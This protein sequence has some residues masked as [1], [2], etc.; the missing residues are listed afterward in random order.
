MVDRAGATGNAVLDHLEPSLVQKLDPDLRPRDLVLRD[1]LTERGEKVEDVF[2]VT[3]GLVSMLTTMADGSSVESGVVGSEGVAGVPAAVGTGRATHG[4]AIVQ[5][6]GRALAMAADRFREMVAEES[7]LRDLVDRYT[8]AVL[9]VATQNVACNRLHPVEGRASR[10]LLMTRDRTE[11]DVFPMT[12]EFLS[13]MLGV[14]RASVSEAAE[15]LQE[16]GAIEYRRGEIRILDRSRLE[17]SACE[18]YAVVSGVFDGL[19][20]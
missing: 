1:V 16:R 11:S 20:D 6:P 14:R 4:T 12:H 3:K 17:A 5:V 13:H 10:W 15:Q 8:N 18:C 2:F 19:Y 9:T 7:H